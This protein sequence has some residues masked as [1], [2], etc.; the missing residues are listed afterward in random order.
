[1]VIDGGVATANKTA[2]RREFR[3]KAG[4]VH[5][6]NGGV[7]PSLLLRSGEWTPLFGDVGSSCQIRFD[8]QLGHRGVTA[9]ASFTPPGQPMS[10]K[11]FIR[12]E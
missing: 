5:W 2:P 10:E 7:E 8:E 6:K 12:A 4:Q 1:M 3:I 9:E 11:Q